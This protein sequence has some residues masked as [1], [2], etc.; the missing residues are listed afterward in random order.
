LPATEVLL[1]GVPFYSQH[2]NVGG[3][4]WRECFSSSCAMLAGFYGRVKTDDEYIL[5]RKPFGDTTSATAQVR[6]LQKLGLQA[7]FHTVG[8]VGLLESEL[9]AGRPVAVGWLHKGPVSRP[10]GGGHWSVVVGFTATHWVHF[11]P[12]GEADMVNGDYVNF[13]EGKGIR[14]TRKNWDRRWMVEG[15]G[16]GWCVTARPA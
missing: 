11:D 5:W 2:D 3:Q 12:Y 1:G 13:T 7:G 15:P 6:T 8:T 14:Y 9:R 4:G 16:S 10:S